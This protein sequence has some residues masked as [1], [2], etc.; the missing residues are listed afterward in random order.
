[1]KINVTE[2]K[3]SKKRYEFELTRS[4]NFLEFLFGKAEQKCKVR[5]MSREEI[6]PTDLKP[7]A[8]ILL[9]NEENWKPMKS[10]KQGCKFSYN[11]PNHPEY[12][13]ITF[14]IFDDQKCTNNADDTITDQEQ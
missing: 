1:M 11:L 2:D 7:L 10:K 13:N 5:L 9:D 14:F 8:Q 3:G 6:E 4:K 12:P